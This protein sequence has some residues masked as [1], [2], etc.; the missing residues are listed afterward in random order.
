MA[1]GKETPRQKMIGMMYLV[2]TA[3][4]ALQVS[5]AVLEKFAIINGTLEGL[6]KESSDKNETSLAG[7][8]EEGSKSN[9]PEIVQ[10]VS[11]AKE[12]RALTD[13][14][15]KYIDGVK[16]KMMEEAGAKT[17][18]EGFINDHSSKVATLMID[19][20]EGQ[21]VGVKFEAELQKYVK[22]LER[23]SGEKFAPLAKSPAQLEAFKNNEKHANKDFLTFTF[24][25]TPPVAALASVTQIQTEVLEY[26][27]TALAAI[28]RKT[29]KVQKKF[30]NIVPMVRPVS[31]VVAAGAE[32]EADMFITASSSAIIP[33]M[34]YNGT[35]LPVEDDPVSKVK[36]GKVKF[37][38]QGG[39]YDKD[40]FA[41]KTFKAKI[42][43]DGEPFEQDIAYTVAQPVI[44][45]T[46]GNAPTLYMNCG[47]TVTIEVPSLGT[48]YN[49]AF[50]GGGAAE[51][52]KGAKA[53]QVTII[54]KQRK[55]TVGVSS[56]GTHIGDA[57]FDVKNVP[58]PKFIAYI[59][60]T[61]VDLRNGIRANQLGNLT[62]KAEPE[63]NFKE[64]V[65]K[66]ARYRIKKA[67]VILG[68]GTAGV[69]RLSAT[70]EV[71]DLRSWIS[72]ARPGDRIVI[73][74]KDVVRKTYK[75]DEEKV[76]VK[77]SSGIIM[78]PV[79]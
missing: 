37:R 57:K 59:G 72:Q 51:V 63:A 61:P 56:G 27:A 22:E 50:S 44:K 78:I 52:I 73:D 36:M 45:V 74:I 55:V 46:T 58:D 53:G 35:K 4:L 62:F 20:K 1:G 19:K 31:S 47:N 68:R 18:D 41:K 5:N 54:P 24:E 38:A 60:S 10:A 65:P 34:Y 40:G 43:I 66:D 2:L 29:G 9:K 64:E 14:T 71:P 48:S 49:P 28:A 70:N 32:Y 75:D 17:I 39:G 8:V 79:N 25:N 23:L 7:I 76:T 77:G 6:I 12:V 21:G 3:L 15:V 26:E 67:D 11:N 16:A 13:K 69:Q 33:E 42:V 30:D